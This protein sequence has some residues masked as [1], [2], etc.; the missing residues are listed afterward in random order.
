MTDRSTY[1]QSLVL[2]IAMLVIVTAMTGY[3]D[4]ESEPCHYTHTS[5]VWR[6]LFIIQLL[7]FF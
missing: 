6:S 4:E 1:M 2:P 7:F 5:D 3:I